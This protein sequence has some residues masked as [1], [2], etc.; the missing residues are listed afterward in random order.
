MMLLTPKLNQ[1]F[2]SRWKA[3]AWAAS[4][5]LSAY[6]A[7]PAADKAKGKADMGAVPVQ[8]HAGDQ[9]KSPWALDGPAGGAG[10]QA[11]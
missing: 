6:C 4:I 3:L 5:M 7:V 2:A 9:A 8:P 11:Q 1:V 10:H